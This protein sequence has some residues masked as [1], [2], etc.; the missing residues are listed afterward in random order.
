VWDFVSGLLKKPDL[1]RAGL[2][3]LIEEERSVSRGNP[4][5]EVK[6]WA[7][8]L[9]EV[10]SKRS[11]YQ[12]QQAEGLITLDELREKL[13]ILESTRAVARRELDALKERRERVET[14]E[15]DAD[16]LL[17][18]YAVMVP[19]ALEDLTSEERHDIYK[20]LRLKVIVSADKPTEETG[21]FGGP[22]KAN[23]HSSA[24]TEG[25]W[26]SARMVGR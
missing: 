2:K 6:A 23:A 1:L 13:A 12:D 14:L 24:K 4:D 11:A 17:E 9:A 20:M 19:E 15:R 16:A 7:K 25:T 8:T 22:V 3:K 18:H 26:R 10:D 21:A 5:R